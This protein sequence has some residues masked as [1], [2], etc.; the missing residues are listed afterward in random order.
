MNKKIDFNQVFA[1]LSEAELL[2]N[3]L[4]KIRKNLLNKK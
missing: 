1:L 2:A 3:R 4:T